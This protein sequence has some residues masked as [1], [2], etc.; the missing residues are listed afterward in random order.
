MTRRLTSILIL[1]ATVSL[2]AYFALPVIFERWMHIPIW[3]LRAAH[4]SEFSADTREGELA[5][6]VIDGIGELGDNDVVPIGSYFFPARNSG[7]F[8]VN[9]KAIRGQ[10]F[11]GEELIPL[12]RVTGFINAR[13]RSD[14]NY[15]ILTPVKG[16]RWG[17]M[18][19]VLDACRRSKAAAVYVNI[20]QYRDYLR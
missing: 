17:E 11:V 2:A 20:D 15:V 6:V 1:G 12:S 13:I 16:A 3:R 19:P 7:F 14:T 4:P 9:L 10:A 18:F 8:A 5:P